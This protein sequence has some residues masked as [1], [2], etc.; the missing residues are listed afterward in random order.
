LP[1]PAP[2]GGPSSSDTPSSGDTPSPGDTPSTGDFPSGSDSPSD[3]GT[4]GNDNADSGLSLYNGKQESPVAVSPYGGVYRQ[5]PTGNDSMDLESVC[6][7][8]KATA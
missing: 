3:N 8:V 5:L 7:F 2:S 6:I 4:P 1:S